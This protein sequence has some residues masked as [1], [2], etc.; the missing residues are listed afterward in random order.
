MR[1]A[2]DQPRQHRGLRQIDHRGARRYCHRKRGGHALTSVVLDDDHHVV[3]QGFSGGVEQM[4]S[5]DIDDLRRGRLRGLLS[6]REQAGGGE[7]RMS[8]AMRFMGGTPSDGKVYGHD[9]VKTK[10]SPQRGEGL[11]TLVSVVKLLISACRRLTR[12]FCSIISPTVF[13]VTEPALLSDVR[14]VTNAS[15]L[16]MAFV[17]CCMRALSEA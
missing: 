5:A 3:T 12:G 17:L 2:V 14:G 7:Q 8:A 6:H 11:W 15:E 1:M 4:A 9:R 13:R 16:S 10:A